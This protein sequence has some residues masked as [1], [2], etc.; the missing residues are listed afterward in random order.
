MNDKLSEALAELIS[1]SVSGVEFLVSEIPDVLHQLLIWKATVS[2]ISMLCWVLL[3]IAIYKFNS[4][5]IK[6][7]IKN[8]K[9][10]EPYL[11]ANLAQAL[12]IIPLIGL[13]D[14]TFLKIWMAPKV[15][16]IEYAAQMVK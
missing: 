13:F 8:K 1:L 14:L 10:D 2:A 7:L 9:F 11:V 12:W 4:W 15:F 6:Y 16:L 5:Q 3:C